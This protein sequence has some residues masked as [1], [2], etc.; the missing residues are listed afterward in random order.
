MGINHINKSFL[1]WKLDVVT[2]FDYSRENIRLFRCTKISSLTKV[3]EVEDIS[4][5]EEIQKKA[6]ETH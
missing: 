1:Y 4:K 5:F 2:V 6:S 3:V